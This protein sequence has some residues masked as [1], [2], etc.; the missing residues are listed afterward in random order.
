MTTQAL[1]LKHNPVLV[2]FPQSPHDLSSRKRPGAWRPGRLG[3]GDYHPCTAEF[4]L[5]RVT[6]RDQPKPWTFTIRSLIPQ[7]FDPPARTGL[8][9]LKEKT[10]RLGS[11]ATENWELDVSDIP[12]QNETLAWKNYRS[13]LAE[14]EN[15]YEPVVYARY[16]DGESGRALQYWYLYLYND[17]RNN[18]E[19]DWEM[20]TIELGPND[21]PVRAAYS[22]HRGG[23]VR[24]WEEV[25]KHQQGGERP[26]LYVAR[27]SHAGHFQYRQGGYHVVNLAWGSKPAFPS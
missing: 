26:L 7:F 22:S 23:F 8:D 27:G 18:H 12:S 19:G 1:L 25:R 2:L 16:V 5:A 13:L 9:S 14:T 24:T 21:Q 6:Q 20:A 4:F 15:P 3:W 10:A 17:F 11:E